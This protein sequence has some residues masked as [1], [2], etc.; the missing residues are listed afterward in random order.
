M[1]KAEPPHAIACYEKASLAIVNVRMSPLI[2][3]CGIRYINKFVQ[4][5]VSCSYLQIFKATVM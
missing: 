4:R 5:F 3:K 2:K 1:Q